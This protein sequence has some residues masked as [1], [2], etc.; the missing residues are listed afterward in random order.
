MFKVNPN[1]TVKRDVT[2]YFPGEGTKMNKGTLVAELKIVPQEELEALLQQ[3]ESALLDRV[4][5]RVY[6]VGDV[7][8]NELPAEEALAAVR[9]DSSASSA[10]AGEYMEMTKG[11]AFRG[12]KPRR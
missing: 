9:A 12:G 8:G 2:V 10:I 3:P 1:N 11:V 4:L 5:V 7:D 6:G